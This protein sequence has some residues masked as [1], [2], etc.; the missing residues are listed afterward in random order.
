MVA[1]TLSCSSSLQ[2][3][4][5]ERSGEA[6]AFRDIGNRQLLWHGSRLSNW[7]GILSQVRGQPL[8]AS[9]R[10]HSNTPFCRVCASHLPR[11]HQQATCS[12]RVSTSRTAHPSLLIT[13]RF[14]CMA[15][16]LQPGHIASSTVSPELDCLRTLL[17]WNLHTHSR[18]HAHSNAACSSQHML[19]LNKSI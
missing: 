7:C 14:A 4:E 18:E 5:V 9:Q 6:D 15:R 13:V 1:Y 8:L 10:F 19:V 12:A 2:A 16:L 17:S 3:F 11:H